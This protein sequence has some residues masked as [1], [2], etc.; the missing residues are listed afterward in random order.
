MI[1]NKLKDFVGI[2]EHDEYEE[3]YEEMNWQQAQKPI[4]PPP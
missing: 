2:S 1:L 4:T 3:E